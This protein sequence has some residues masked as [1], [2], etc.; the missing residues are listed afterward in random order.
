MSAVNG[1]RAR[2]RPGGRLARKSSKRPSLGGAVAHNA[3]CP[4]NP[5]VGLSRGGDMRKVSRLSWKWRGCSLIKI[6]QRT[7][8][9][10]FLAAFLAGIAWPPSLTSESSNSVS[11]RSIT[12]GA[13]ILSRRAGFTLGIEIYLRR[14]RDLCLLSTLWR[15]LRRRAREAAH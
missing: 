12:L 2:R 6:G 15:I 14:P 10:E 9:K 8:E 5:A 13:S 1:S 4:K 7:P 11:K 3:G